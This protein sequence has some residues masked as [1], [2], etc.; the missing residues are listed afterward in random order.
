M[1]PEEIALFE[2]SLVREAGRLWDHFRSQGGPRPQLDW[3][4]DLVRLAKHARVRGLRTLSERD[5][6]WLQEA[7]RLYQQGGFEKLSKAVFQ[8]RA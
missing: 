3:L 5:R 2:A 6:W 4:W 7:I 8:G 1:D